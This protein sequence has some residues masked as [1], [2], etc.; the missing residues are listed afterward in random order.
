MKRSCLR[1]LSSRTYHW[2]Y[3]RVEHEQRRVADVELVIQHNRSIQEGSFGSM[4][5]FHHETDR[6]YPKHWR[7]LVHLRFPTRN[8]AS[9]WNLH[10]HTL[11]R[12]DSWTCCSYVLHDCHYENTGHRYSC[13]ERSNMFYIDRRWYSR[14]RRDHRSG[15]C[16]TRELCRWTLA[17]FDCLEDIEER[18]SLVYR[19]FRFHEY[20][21]W[22]VVPVPLCPRFAGRVQLLI[23]PVLNSSNQSYP[24]KST[25]INLGGKESLS[26]HVNIEGENKQLLCVCLSRMLDD[27]FH[28]KRER[29]NGKDNNQSDDD[30]D[31]KANRTRRGMIKQLPWRVLSKV[32][33]S[34]STK[35]Y[36]PPHGE[37]FKDNVD[38]L[39]A[40]LSHFQ[41][42]KIRHGVG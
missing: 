14:S 41:S 1:G 18:K 21:L 38:Q 35:I 29:A 2:W 28:D 26:E 33:F 16:W 24:W 5:D 8:H 36:V 22:S 6:T 3:W 40:F 30:E 42:I 32:F 20:C 7:E 37:P 19:Y 17:W 12:L 11:H 31:G 4:D 34:F 15:H 9:R 25:R 39:E 27:S 10:N 13:R 23:L